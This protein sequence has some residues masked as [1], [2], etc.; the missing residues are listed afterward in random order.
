ME[1]KLLLMKSK[2]LLLLLL[3]PL[4]LLLGNAS[5]RLRR[6]HLVGERVEGSNDN[7]GGDARTKALEQEPLRKKPT[8]SSFGPRKEQARGR[9]VCSTIPPPPG[10]YTTANPYRGGRTYGLMSRVVRSG[11]ERQL[12]GSLV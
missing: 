1:S 7:R 2:L 12:T 9:V 4:L 6:E 11:L 10:F 3:L 8:L 5:D